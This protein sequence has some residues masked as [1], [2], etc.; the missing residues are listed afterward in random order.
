M[1]NAA[2]RKKLLVANRALTS[3]FRSR[4]RAASPLLLDVDRAAEDRDAGAGLPAQRDRIIT[5]KGLRV[6]KELAPK[7]RSRSISRMRSSGFRIPR[8]PMV[9][10]D[11]PLTEEAIKAFRD[12]NLRV[13]IIIIWRE[14]LNMFRGLRQ[15]PLWNR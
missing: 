12:H 11:V 3:N 7:K 2:V 15:I 8:C 14:G 9:W 1:L 4:D 5:E 13:S 10:G 6:Y